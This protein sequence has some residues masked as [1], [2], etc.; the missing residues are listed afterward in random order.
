MERQHQIKRTLAAPESIDAVR[1]LLAEGM[2]ANRSALVHA[3]CNHFGFVD[4]RGRAQTAGCVKALRELEHAGHFVLPAAGPRGRRRGQLGSARR[5]GV[6]VPEP[7]DMPALAGDVRGLALVKVQTLEQLR[8]WNE[9][10]AREHPQGAGP[11]VGAQ[12]RYL[13]ES[14]HGW[15]GGLGFAAAALNL[16]DRDRWIGWDAATRREHLHRVVGMARFLIRRSVRCHNLA[17][18]VLGMAAR[19]V[20]A[21]YE[22]QYGYRPWLLESFVDT[23]QFLGTCYQAAN[24]LAVGHSR[25][26]GRQDRAHQAT[27]SVKAIYVYALAADWRERMGVPEPRGPEPLHPGEGLD[28]HE[29]AQ[30][31]FGGADLGDLRLQ[32]RLVECARALGVQ[33]GRAFCGAASGDVAAVKAYYR[34]IGLPDAEEA[35]TMQAMLAPHRQRTL[36]RMMAQPL[37]LCVQDGTELNYTNLA[38]CQGLGSL[39]TNQTGARSMG[40]HLHSTLALTAEGLPLGVLD[41]SCQ[42][43]PARDADDQRTSANIPIEEK[44]T[45]DWIQGLRQCEQAAAR[46]PQ[47]RLVSVM[48]READFFELFDEQRRRDKVDLLVRAKHDR[49]INDPL[50]AEQR[51]LFDQVRSG[52]VM[53]RLVIAVPRQS[54]RPKKSKSQARAGHPKR[55]AQ[56]QLRHREVVLPPPKHHAGKPALRLWVVHVRETRAPAGAARLEWFLLSTRA[57]TTVEQACECLR[58]YC[59]RWRIE[60]WH[61]VLK[62]GC[63]VEALQHKTATR[64]KRAI[65]FNLVIAWR[66]ML[67]TLLGRQAPELPADVLFS[68]LEI[69]VLQAYAKKTAS[70][71]PYCSARPSAS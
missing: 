44:K 12:L 49:C 10:M 57:I 18:R 48:D 35:V 21:D 5:L 59:L 47:T 45:F 20:A 42:A 36:Q 37:V 71:D 51:T 39:G 19:A 16:A 26:R 67:L 40:L 38:Q 3:T 6:P 13:I 24:W 34:F 23:E 50:S 11:L 62:S 8:L 27:K 69:E 4:A 2:H 63:R 56:V 58:W 65:A 9:L 46:M 32:R 30:H 22:T 28:G 43:P 60:D 33:P 17:S 70:N 1:R 54:S 29:W 68:D 7:H 52:P 61:R 15:L 55:M 53:S 64:L 41:A 14:E 25:G 31:E 66:I